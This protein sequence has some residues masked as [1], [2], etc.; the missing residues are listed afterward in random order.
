L[1]LTSFGGVLGST[2]DQTTPSDRRE[3]FSESWPLP[4][5][6]VGMSKSY[7]DVALI[8]NGLAIRTI[9]LNKFIEFD[10]ETGILE[11]EPGVLLREIQATFVKRGWMLAV[12]PGTS[13]V[14]VG[15]AIA[16]DVHGKDHHFAGTFGDHV[17]SLELATSKGGLLTCSDEANSGLFRATIG[18]LGLT[19][20]ITSARIQ[21]KSVAGPYFEAE[22]I[23][24]GNLAEFFSIS[25]QTESE[26]W[27]ASVAWF[28]CSTRW[29]GR[30]SFTRGNSSKR[31]YDS[32]K[33]DAK[34]N[35]NA[36]NITFPVKPPFSL[37]NKF[38]L[39]SF[40]HA[41]FQLQKAVSGKSQMHY[42]DFY[43][44]L[45]GVT[46]WN[47]IYGPKGFFQY[48]SVVPMES[49]SEATREMLEAI[50]RSGE[51]SFL[52]VI[53]T[54]A[55][56]KSAGLLS[57]AKHGVTL[58]L[59]FPNRG[60]STERLFNTLDR[61]VRDAGGRLNPSKDARMSRE[62]FAKGYPELTKFL[63]YRDPGFSSDFSRRLID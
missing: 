55:D 61:I 12:T 59:D 1:N 45:D 18:G 43:Y 57:F 34:L 4:A 27:E 28:D 63:K 19:G 36:R 42:K 15:G 60:A 3:A 26:N 50:R 23:P 41:Y 47:R 31:E 35:L 17:V 14:T 40:N 39:D 24:F 6:A 20:L 16:N 30:G 11:C 54:F 25:E 2:S 44:P 22:S 56:K 8:S 7:G 48:Q 21:L 58:A 62:M 52:G 13:Y 53:K 46:N 29:A 32:L 9:G 37:I 10:P 49:A 33:D 51:G 38:T 5:L